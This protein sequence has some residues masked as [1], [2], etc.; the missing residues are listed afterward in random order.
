VCLVVLAVGQSEEYPL[1]L[2]GNRDEFHSRPTQKAHWWSDKP[3][4]VGG[5]DLQAGGTW[6][7]LHRDGRYAAVTNFR[8]AEPVS[9]GFRSRGHLVTEFLESGQLPLRYLEAIDGTAYAGFNLIVGDV[10]NAAF[11]SNRDG[12]PRSLPAGLYGLSNEL[13]DG[14]WDKV[15][16]SKG[17]LAALL[18]RN[19]VNETTLLRLL[20]DRSKGPIEEVDS[21]S[22]GFAK[23][24]AIT[25]P[26]IVTPD[27]GTRCST[28]VLADSSGKWRMVE[29]RF[30]PRGLSTGESRFTFAARP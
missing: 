29:R 1:I 26:F 27:Y 19:G 25:A 28:V 4:I 13:L 22:L 9:P 30:D 2:A 15:R 23:A 14:P 24:H 5:R 6:L 12:G 20:D 8:D 10:N 18:A 16:R 7:A 3:N 21:S 17:A 11:L